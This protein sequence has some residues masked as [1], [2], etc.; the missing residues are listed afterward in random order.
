MGKFQLF[1][2]QQSQSHRYQVKLE[3]NSILISLY[4]DHGEN[5]VGVFAQQRIIITF[6]IQSVIFVS[7]VKTPHFALRL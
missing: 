3:N 4:F 6:C 1:F 7:I 5:T 2:L